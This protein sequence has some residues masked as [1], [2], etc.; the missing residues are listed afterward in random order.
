[1]IEPMHLRIQYGNWF[2]E[3]L[4]YGP[5]DMGGY[6][7]IFPNLEVFYSDVDALPVFFEHRSFHLVGS[8]QWTDC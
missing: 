2:G 6:K 4:E 8:A 1:M 7:Q 5:N 3:N